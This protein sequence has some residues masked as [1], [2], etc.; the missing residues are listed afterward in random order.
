MTQKE[1]LH[2]VYVTMSKR[3]YKLKVVKFLEQWLCGTE[4]QKW[5]SFL[6]HC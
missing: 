5:C 1:G 3:I 6:D 2:R 4:N